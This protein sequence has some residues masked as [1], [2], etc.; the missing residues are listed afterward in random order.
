MSASEALP[1]LLWVDGAPCPRVPADDRGL[2]Y[3]D[4]V[5]RTLRVIGG[6][7]GLLERHLRKL[8][9]DARALAMVAE[10]EL[11]DLLRREIAALLPEQ[12]GVL[13][14]TL[15]RGSGPRG[16][17]APARQ[18]PRRVL[19]F[20]PTT[21]PRLEAT[22]VRMQVARTPLACSPALAGIKHL[23]RLEQVLAASESSA[24]NVFDRLM[25]E[26]DGRPICGTRCN[27]FLRR[28]RSLLTPA[29]TRSG[30]AGAV[31]ERILEDAGS[32]VAGIVDECREAV[33]DLDDLLDADELFVTNAVFGLRVVGELLDAD[34]RSLFA[35]SRAGPLAHRLL[36]ALASDFP[37]PVDSV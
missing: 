5:F 15:T 31:R 22:P 17:A 7:P 1:G 37:S 2:L 11:L 6:R 32:I 21:P 24:A 19:A 14:I 29:L 18:T 35:R 10:D 9:A 33:L 20:T 8:G 23:G 36:A 30:V 16:Y 26:P 12:D 4:G 25:C 34:G 27:L 3:G 28:G 13:R